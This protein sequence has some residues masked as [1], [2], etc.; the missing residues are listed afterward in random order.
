MSQSHQ[1]RIPPL[2]AVCDYEAAQRPG[3]SVEQSVDLLRRY[4]FLKKQLVQLATAHLNRTPEWEVKSALS[5]HAW[6]DAEHASWMAQRVG[7]MREP[8]LR[9]EDDPDAGLRALI[10]EMLRAH[11]TVELLSGIYR[12][13]RPALLAAYQRHRRETNPLVDHATCRLL[14]F[15]ILEEEEMIAWGKSA[16]V[17]LLADDHSEQK[18]A[19]GWEAHLTAYLDAAGGITGEAQP[20]PAEKLPAPRA[21]QAYK[22]DLTPQRDR[23]FSGLFNTTTPADLVYVDELRG[24]AER[25]LALLFKRLRE[26]DVPEVVAGIMAE[27]RGKPWQY[28]HDMARQLWD[29]ARHSM[30]GEV[31]LA[32]R[33]LDWTRLP[34]NVTFSYK[35]N[36]WLTAEERHILL[37][38]IEQS[39]MPAKVGK[40]LEWEIARGSGDPLSTTFHDFDWADEVLHVAI[41]RAC[42]LAHLPGGREE[43]M[44][45][46]PA[47]W[48]KLEAALQSEP[49]P[50]QD[51][52][53]WWVAFASA[54]L[55]FPVE[56]VR[57]PEN[58]WRPKTG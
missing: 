38:H 10:E 45:R 19:T 22:L 31:A 6:L 41:G 17:A 12:V 52:R 36:R 28:Y 9:L 53:E 15:M 55:G 7:E 33:G 2:A 16:L 54:A 35:L 49:F 30:M 27:T 42:L 4:H 39:L 24:F 44:A 13:L 23:R 46:A 43:A 29:E 32:Q 21:R 26:M 58:M 1:P 5:L 40:R 3:Y 37:Y 11:D 18:R 14:R 51:A 56:A 57:Q 50:E 47:I 8:P 48:Q 34:I 25:N 20:E